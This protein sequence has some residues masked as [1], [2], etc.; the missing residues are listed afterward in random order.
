MTHEGELR[1]DSQFLSLEIDVKRQREEGSDQQ[2]SF[3]APEEI[4]HNPKAIAILC[5]QVRLPQIVEGF[6]TGMNSLI[7]GPQKVDTFVRGLFEQPLELGQRL[8][9]RC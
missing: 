2:Q 4:P 7:V 9:K 1:A 6:Q 8:W 5:L 3:V